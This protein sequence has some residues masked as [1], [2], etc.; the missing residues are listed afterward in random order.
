MQQQ[1]AGSTGWYSTSN[2]TS[3][4]AGSGSGGLGNAI[5]NG[6]GGGNSPLQQHLNRLTQ[7]NQ[8]HLLRHH[9]LTL[10]GAGGPLPLSASVA[11]AGSALSSMVGAQNPA[12]VMPP[13]PHLA[14][15][16]SPGTA[17]RVRAGT[18]AADTAPLGSPLAAQPPSPLASLQMPA[19]ARAAAAGAARVPVPIPVP[20]PGYGAHGHGHGNANITGTGSGLRSPVV[21]AS[22]AGPIGR[23]VGAS[24]ALA[25]GTPLTSG[26]LG[27]ALSALGA[28]DGGDG[29][30]GLAPSFMQRA[31]SAVA[32]AAA[33]GGAG[34]AQGGAPRVAATVQGMLASPFLPST[35]MVPLPGLADAA[36]DAA[37]A[38]AMSDEAAYQ[39]R[40]APGVTVEG[41]DAGGHARRSSRRR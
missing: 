23:R 2:S 6:N 27:V 26:A 31:P 17:A 30:A 37:A 24:P 9:R 20:G 19:H 13:P 32:A 34:S 29:D 36:A 40:Q 28:L 39:S 1:Q 22:P 16:P 35:S 33:G 12:T 38:A 10:P 7:L 3:V 11:P 21:G 41:E 5:G 4:G 15:Y 25:A 8:S 18:S 14:Y